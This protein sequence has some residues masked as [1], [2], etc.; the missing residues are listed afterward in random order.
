MPWHELLAQ[1]LG[2]LSDSELEDLT[3]A[4]EQ[5]G[6]SWSSLVDGVQDAAVVARLTSLAAAVGK[7]RSV[8]S[9]PYVITETPSGWVGEYVRKR[10]GVGKTRRLTNF[11]PRVESLLYDEQRPEVLW[12]QGVIH[13][14]H[15]EVLP[16]V[17]KSANEKCTAWLN[18]LSSTYNPP[19]PLFSELSLQKL[20]EVAQKFCTPTRTPAATRI[21]WNQTRQEFVFPHCSIHKGAVRC[22]RQYASV[23]EH[24]TAQL[25]VDAS[26]GL[27]SVPE[28]TGAARAFWATCATLLCNILAPAYGVSTAGIGVAGKS[29]QTLS[30][31]V[32]TAFGCKHDI[33]YKST[34]TEEHLHNWPVVVQYT[35]YRDAAQARR[36]YLGWALSS[37]HN[38][39][40]LFS[41]TVAEC[42]VARGGWMA[43][44]EPKAFVMPYETLENT[45][46]LLMSYLL[47]LTARRLVL[48]YDGEL[49]PRWFDQVLCDLA[50][51]VE[52]SG[53]RKAEVLRARS[54]V[55]TP[56]L[57]DRLTVFVSLLQSMVLSAQ[58]RT[59]ERYDRDFT[60]LQPAMRR[61]GNNGVWLNH[62]AFARAASLVRIPA[63]TY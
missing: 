51:F 54:L 38:A 39:I 1:A 32:A 20:L 59:G 22:N 5:D 6:L 46:S 27:W 53:G 33:P 24:P 58:L 28:E 34:V 56:D 21:G 10:P 48:N 14:E 19:Q 18:R 55:W 63:C 60:P 17:V 37:Q 16:F 11:I 45:D 29:L 2:K 31:A 61:V 49:P 25:R 9:E 35:D 30:I 52:R 62:Q 47:D 44:A 12:Q 36:S 13:T 7:Y 23:G 41:N 57:D 15:G 4:C 40:G 8:V 26:N 42:L 43:I 3:V 50:L